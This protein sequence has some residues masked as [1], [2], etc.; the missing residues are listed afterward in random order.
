MGKQTLLQ[1]VQGV[2]A[3]LV[4]DEVNSIGDTNEAMVVANIVR[5]TYIDIANEMDLPADR[6]ITSL[7]PYSDTTKPT[8]LKIPENVS[9]V[10]WLKYD[11]RT[12]TAGNKAYTDITWMAP[13][14]F[15]S[16]VN[17]RPST[18]TTNYKVVM[19]SADVP[20]IINKKAGPTY[21]TCFD[22]NTIIFDNFNSSV[23]STI[24][25]SKTLAYVEKSPELV[26]ADATI[27]NLPENLNS[28]LYTMALT[29][30][31]LDL[32]KEPNQK[33]ERNESRMRVRAMRNKW[34]QGRI[35]DDDPNYGRK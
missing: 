13:D 12:S 8:F 27:I 3:E 25:A 24:Q 4:S 17:A 21:W 26:L 29:R 9:K 5:R 18:D 1:T 23:D 35:I 6:D 19:Y 33:G 2:L 15:I 14:D 20:L 11:V 30:C 10:I 34:R 31:S 16:Y 28:L 7:E 22:D 32:N